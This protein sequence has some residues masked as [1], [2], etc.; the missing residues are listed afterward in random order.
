MRC[1]DMNELI[2]VHQGRLID[3]TIERHLA[4][5]PS[6]QTHWRMLSELSLL[7]DTEP[8]VPEEWMRQVMARWDAGEVVEPRTEATLGQRFLAAALAVLACSFA[9]FAGGSL[10]SGSPLL[11]GAFSAAAAVIGWFALPRGG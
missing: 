6:C 7:A 2:D 1:P 5:C 8:E 9:L 4:T 11:F 3:L 10:G